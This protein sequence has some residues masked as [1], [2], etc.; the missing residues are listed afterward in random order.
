LLG[1]VGLPVASLLL[2]LQVSTSDCVYTQDLGLSG[3]F[4]IGYAFPM[5]YSVEAVRYVQFGSVHRIGFDMGILTIY[6]VVFLFANAYLTY[7]R[8]KQRV[9]AQKSKPEPVVSHTSSNP[10]TS[11]ELVSPSKTESGTANSPLQNEN[12]DPNIYVP[13]TNNS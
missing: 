3:F 2:I 6:F 7:I 13:Q 11:V 10:S 1:P 4:K 5:Y 12:I 8:T 9:E